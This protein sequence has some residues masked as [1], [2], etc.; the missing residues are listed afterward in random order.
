V[1]ALV[2]ALAGTAVAG[3]QATT[4]AINK[5]KV[6]KIATKQATKQINE[7]APGLSVASAANANA[8]GGKPPTAYA[9]PTSYRV[10]QGVTTITNLPTGETRVA[11]CRPEEQV[12]A[13]G[14]DST[15][16]AVALA[17]SLPADGP[18]GWTATFRNN[19]P[20]QVGEVQ[21]TAFAVCAS[22]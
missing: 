17:T 6:K 22:T 15:I 12:I 16:G 3:P 19:S 10:A 7:L 5:K 8:L 13:G 1:L 21:L 11:R 9:S 2:A 20:N 14:G 18:S 4:S